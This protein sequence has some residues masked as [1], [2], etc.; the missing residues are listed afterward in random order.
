MAG[1]EPASEFFLQL[2]MNL[3]T[4]FMEQVIPVLRTEKPLD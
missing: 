4:I 3:S 2:K 1:A